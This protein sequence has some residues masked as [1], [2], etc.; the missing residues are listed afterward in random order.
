MYM[1][2]GYSGHIACGLLC[3]TRS[4]QSAIKIKIKTLKQSVHDLDFRTLCWLWLETAQDFG[5]NFVVRSILGRQIF[6]EHQ[7]CT[8]SFKNRKAGILGMRRQLQ[9][10]VLGLQRA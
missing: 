4:S 6:R 5:K 3:F 1:D 10:S 7:G 8:R 9:F 2:L